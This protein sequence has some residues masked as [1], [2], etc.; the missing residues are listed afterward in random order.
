MQLQ[1]RDG[2]DLAILAFPDQGGLVAAR[3]VQ[4][5]I[6]AVV[7][8]VELTA[9]EP[10][11]V[12]RRPLHDRVPLAEPVELL[13]S[14]GPV[15]FGVVESLRVESLVVD[16]GLRAER[17]GGRELA[18]LVEQIVEHRVGCA[19]PS[20]SA[21]SGQGLFE[22]SNFFVAMMHVKSLAR[23]PGCVSR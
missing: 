8:Q 12:G 15:G 3:A 21:N 2:A 1:I 11:H 20:T 14:L 9:D 16:V 5:S 4:V 19:H 10:L 17:I 18:V 6:D 7:R 23:P 22:A 13:G